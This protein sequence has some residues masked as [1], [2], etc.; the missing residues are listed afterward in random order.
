MSQLCDLSGRFNAWSLRCNMPKPN[1]TSTDTFV[2]L[3]EATD[4]IA[5]GKAKLGCGCASLTLAYIVLKECALCEKWN[6]ELVMGAIV[7]TTIALVYGSILGYQIDL[8]RTGKITKLAACARALVMVW[9]L[10]LYF[11]GWDYYNRNYYQ[12]PPRKASRS[13]WFA[14]PSTFPIPVGTATCKPNERADR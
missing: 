3:R 13:G 11:L 8:C 1:E 7:Y 4:N 12:P 6:D 10:L 14:T 2:L 5:P 9:I